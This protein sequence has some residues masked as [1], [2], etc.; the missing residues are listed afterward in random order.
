MKRIATL[1][2]LLMVTL[3]AAAA[4]VSQIVNNEI[5]HS[6]QPVNLGVIVESLNNNRILYQHHAN[7]LFIPASTMKLFTAAA[8]L[9][10]LGGNFRFHTYI[11]GQ[12]HAIYFKFNGDPSFTRDDLKHSVAQLKAKGIKSITGSIYLDTHQFDQVPY[13]PGWI[14]DDLA[15][16]YAAAMNAA[17][18]NENSFA[19]RIAPGQHNQSITHLSTPTLPA[20]TV[21][22]RNSLYTS[23]DKRACVVAIYS[24]HNNQYWVNGCYKKRWRVAYR[25]LGL[26]DPRAYA[27][28]EI[29][30]ALN[31]AGI[32]FTGKIRNGTAPKHAKILVSHQ[33]KPLAILIKHMLKTS[34]NIYADSLFKTLGARYFHTQ[35]TWQN[36]EKALDAILSKAT[37]IDFKRTLITDGAGLSRYDLISPRQLQKLLEWIYHDNDIAP[38]LMS[39]LPIAGTD[40]TLKYRMRLIK[41]PSKIRAKTGTMHGVTTLAGFAT[42]GKKALSFVIMIN[43]FVGKA[44]PY[45]DI[46]D[47]IG[48]RLA[49]LL[50]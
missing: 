6:R 44:T 13:A 32:S 20:N 42:R 10:Y 34:D 2:T 18:I 5:N 30:Q 9:D 43:N 15:Y 11:L 19:L 16:N 4:S 35:G 46:E 3:T 28:M 36:G 12:H 1:C 49:A 21:T 39:A 17:I 33:S 29:R 7:R 26:S 31:D 37:G 25:N 50:Q 14:W 38:E 45:R 22:L 40:G 41:R 27:R 8:A 48:E 23:T 47:H 24:L